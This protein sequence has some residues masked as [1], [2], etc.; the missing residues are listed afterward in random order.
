MSLIFIIR[1]LFSYF[2]KINNL[3]KRIQSY[4]D[5]LQFKHDYW[6]NNIKEYEIAF[7]T[8]K[9]LLFSIPKSISKGTIKRS[10]EIRENGKVINTVKV[11]QPDRT[12]KR[13]RQEGK[14]YF[15][16]LDW[17]DLID[18]DTLKLACASK[19]P[20]EFNKKYQEFAKNITDIKKE[21]N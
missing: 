17:K 13:I 4:K 1:L 21:N 18:F 11:T 14:L 9:G 19:T 12:V 15:E 8:L 5:E 20:D 10:F 3:E 6:K 7:I 16:Y 2:S